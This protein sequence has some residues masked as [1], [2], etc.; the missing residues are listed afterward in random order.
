ME[1]E[2]L[3]I[4]RGRK[5]AEGQYGTTK[6]SWALQLCINTNTREARGTGVLIGHFPPPMSKKRIYMP[7][8]PGFQNLE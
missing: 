8:A 6:V 4:R 7:A 2:N 5:G 3:E 1:A